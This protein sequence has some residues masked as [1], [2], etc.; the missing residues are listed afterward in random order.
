[1]NI[2]V[3][4]KPFIKEPPVICSFNY[5]VNSI[6]FNTSITFNVV[7][8]DANKND[9]KFTQIALSG[10]D[11]ANW[12]INDDYVIDYI[13]KQL[14]LTRL[15]NDN[16][17]PVVVEENPVVVEENPVVVEEN[18]VVVEEKSGTNN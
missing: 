5:F 3:N 13:C 1:M 2:Q 17:N 14:D 7:L 11:Y 18:P 15:T 6:I 4:P 16:E 12:G 10:D 8:L 9:I